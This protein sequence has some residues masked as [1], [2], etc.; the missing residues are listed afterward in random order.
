[1]KHLALGLL[2]VLGTQDGASLKLRK[3]DHIC[4]VGNNLADRMQHYPWL[5]TFIQSRFP[6]HGLVFRNLGFTG[7][8]VNKRPRSRDFGSPD[9]HLRHNKADVIFAFFGY[10]ESF[11]G[12][13]GVGNFRKALSEF[14]ART[15]K[16]NYSGKGAPRLVLFS[17]IAHEDLKS[18]HLP[19]GKENNARLALYAKAMAEVARAAGVTFVDLFGPTRAEYEKN[20]EPLTLNGIHLNDRGNRI[21]AEIIDGALFGPRPS[22][23]RPSE[24]EL[25]KLHAAIRDKNFHWFNRYRTVD[26]YNVYGGRSKLNWHGQ[27]NADVMK[28]EM[29]IFDVMTA[30]RDKRVWAAAQGRD[31]KIDDSNVP[32]LI[33]VKTNRPGRGPNGTYPYL[34]GEEAISKMK[35]AKGMEINLFAS[36]ETHP[37]LINPV[38]LAVDTDSRL[39]AVLWPTYPHWNPRKPLDDKIVILPDENGDGKADKLIVF[40]DGLN[41][42]TGFE[43]WNGGVLVAAAPEILFL[44]DTDGDDRADVRIRMLQGVSSAD[45]HHTANALTIGPAGGLYYSRG[46]FHVTNMETPTKT[47]RSTRTG[48]YRFDPRT[49]EIGFHFPVGPNPHGDVFDGWGYQFVSDGT[50]GTGYYVG[51]GKGKGAPKQWYRKRV[52]PVPAIGMLSSSH[53]PPENDGN[54]LICNVIGFLGVLQHRIEYTGAD[55]NAIEAEPIVVS[56]DPNFRP[57]DVEVGGDGALYIADWQNALIGHMQHNIRDPNRDHAHGRVY[58]VTAKG[59]PL[60]KP[61][62]MK[63]KPIRQVLEHFRAKESGTRYRARLELTGRSRKEIVS[64]VGKWTATLD[65]RNV[66]DEMPLLNALWVFEEQR[67][68]NEPLLKKVFQASEPRVRA[69]AIRTLGHW[70]PKVKDWASLLLAAARDKE[71]L[72]RHE[73]VVAAPSFEGLAAAEAIF[74]AAIRPTD[75]QLDYALNDSRKSLNV[76]KFVQEA[77]RAGKKLSP[78]AQ[79]YALK[80]TSIGNLVRMERSEA[81]CEALLTRTGVNERDRRAALD[82]LAKIR[83]TSALAVLLSAIAN[84]EGR[85]G[86]TLGDLAKLLA[87]W[88]ASEL[89]G[90]KAQVYTLATSAKNAD[91]KQAA[92]AA[93]VAADGSTDRVMRLAGTSLGNMQTFMQALRYVKDPGTLQAIYPTV[94]TL[95]RELPKNLMSDVLGTPGTSGRYV[96]VELPRRGTLTLAEVQIFSGGRDIAKGKKARQSSTAHNGKAARAVDGNTNGRYGANTSTHT[97]ENSRRPW[98]EVD[99]GSEQPV[100]RI[101]VWNRTDGSLGNRLDN[102]KISVLDGGRKAVWSKDKNKAPKD[103]VAFDLGGDPAAGI[104]AAAIAA[105]VAIPGHDAEN[106]QHLSTLIAD[107]RRASSAIPALLK[108]RTSKWSKEKAPG[109]AAALKAFVPT[110]PL[111]KRTGKVFK[112]CQALAKQLGGFLPA[113]EARALNEVI[114]NQ[115]LQ[116]VRIRTVP[117]QMRYDKVGFAV[118]AGK[119]VRIVLENLDMMPHNLLVVMPDSAKVVGPLAEKMGAEG[120]RKHFRPDS[121]LILHATRLINNGEVAT[122]DFNAPDRPG[123]YE[124][125][126]TFPGHWILMRG[127]MKVVRTAAELPANSAGIGASMVQSWKIADFEKD[128]GSLSGRSFKKGK[129]AF[130][131]LGCAQ[132]HKIGGQGGV[133]GPDLTE[134]FK[135]WKFSRRDMLLQV[136]EPSKVVE[137]KYKPYHLM[138]I[139]G[140][141]LFGLVTEKTKTHLTIVTNPQNPVPQKIAVKDIEKQKV[142][143]LSLMPQGLLNLLKRE[144]ILDLLAYLESGGNRSYKAFKK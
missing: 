85:Y 108:I 14:I 52:R 88:S 48:V 71:P 118:V 128:L 120:F 21:V 141:H 111:N 42:V 102:F 132:C 119:P 124:Y 130:T 33:P 73:A 81:V 95:T 62:K 4:H 101:V 34:G 72:V 26:G 96:R 70:G 36:E 98:W 109:L 114:A 25:R 37:G 131:K 117:E 15:K 105:L 11:A 12:E 100:G 2:L 83:S 126:C 92:F 46:V 115:D 78:S 80:N 136:L 22:A 13:G 61:A 103:K 67:I 63:G 66:A 129:A 35:I 68:V 50:S 5:E 140:E 127:V 59:R 77:L 106:F 56:S 20:A 135:K 57:S 110:I 38:Q 69:A 121:D 27:S 94:K 116:V 49:F 112:D 55:I 64:E 53:F 74:E 86:V 99:L 23:A 138:T 6:K 24:A 16:Q 17:P 144:E 107:G 113:A 104:H 10:N 43:F 134:S 41:S 91:V 133:L 45:S 18:P 65:A 44:K 75:V 47:F 54:F 31:V 60:L 79:A 97:K 76:D 29:E 51:L 3:G 90:E 82:A 58:R 123:D 122:L 28:R 8:E 19:D 7:D 1:M 143:S 89:K 87:G 39:W 142:A 30:N 40:A 137:E 84:P 32:P 139:R 125:V 9:D 93:L